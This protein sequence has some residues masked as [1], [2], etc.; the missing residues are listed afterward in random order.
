MIN[1]S[2]S[3][4]SERATPSQVDCAACPHGC[5]ANRFEG[6]FGFCQSDTGLNIASICEHHGEEPV[7]S[8]KNG[9]CNLFFAHCN[10]QCIYC[11]NYQISRNNGEPQRYRRNLEEVVDQVVLI[12]SGGSRAVGFV[13]PSHFVPQVRSI[14][15][16]IMER[17]WRPTFVFNTN[18]YDRW[19][20]IASHPTTHMLQQRRSRRCIVKW[21]PT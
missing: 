10:M 15:G 4:G 2:E 7:I 5:H 18:A 11:Q 17:A 1:D 14:V 9:I 3:P 21:G 20:T 8:G 13:S 6:K 19:Q 12:L 16:A